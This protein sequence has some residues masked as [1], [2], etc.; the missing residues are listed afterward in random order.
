[1]IRAHR[2]FAL[3]ISTLLL[4][5]PAALLPSSVSP[6]QGRTALIL[7]CCGW[8]CPGCGLVEPGS[9]NAL[10]PRWITPA[11]RTDLTADPHGISRI[12]S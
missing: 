6:V 8:L 7:D 3:T 1:M 9:E 11:Q 4:C 2:L 12:V 5:A 10:T